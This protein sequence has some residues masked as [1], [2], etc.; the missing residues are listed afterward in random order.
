MHLDYW[1]FKSFLTN[2]SFTV[3][4][5]VFLIF[6]VQHCIDMYQYVLHKV[7]PNAQCN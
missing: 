2:K 7:L 4:F 5:V 6:A 3:I 1:T